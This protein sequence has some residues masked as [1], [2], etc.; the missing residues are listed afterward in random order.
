MKININQLLEKYWNAEASLQEEAELRAYFSSN[1]VAPEHEQFNDLFTFFS[2]SRLQSTDLDVEGIFNN[3]SD[4]DL[5]LEKYW[6][7]E[8]S[9]DDETQLK[10]YFSGENIAAEHIQFKDLF[11]FYDVS[12]S[13]ITDMEF[14][15]D[16]NINDR[17]EAL[18][19]KYWNTETSLEEEQLL[20]TYFASNDIA[21]EHEEFRG[22]FS[23]LS[24][25]SNMT[26]DLDVSEILINAE[27]KKGNRAI[28]S[29][30]MPREARSKVFSL[31]KWAVGMAAVFVM[32]FAAITLMNQE[33]QTQYKGHSTVLDEEAE[34]R[35]AYEITKEALAFLSKNM[36]TGSKTVVESVSKAEKVSIF[37]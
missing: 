20:R 36:N 12:K 29:T 33:T 1:D 30:E 31:Q 19:E 21:P 9:L 26:T 7:A 14:K 16:F 11:T 10:K 22:V 15:P 17:I 4:I 37:K 13:Q 2:V 35:E 27:D 5:L 32:G 24:E 28:G 6:N 23:L 3:L 18:L 8:T 34:A 25:A